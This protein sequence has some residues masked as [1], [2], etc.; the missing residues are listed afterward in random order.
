MEMDW[1]WSRNEIDGDGAAAPQTRMQGLSTRKNRRRKCDCVRVGTINITAGYGKAAANL[2]AV[3]REGHDKHLDLI[4]CTETRIG[5]DKHAQ[6]SG[7]YKIFATE[8]AQNRGGVAFFIRQRRVDEPALSW[9]VE[10]PQVFDTNVAAVTLVS[11]LWRRRIIGVYLSPTDI[12]DATWAGLHRACD[13]ATD[14]IWMMGDYNANLHDT[15]D[16]RVNEA[17]GASARST[18][19]AEIQAFISSLGIRSFGRTKLHRRKQ[20]FWT[21][22]L[23]R[24]VQ[25]AEQ[26]IKSV[27]D[28]ILGPRTD[29]IVKYRTRDVKWI[30]TDHR[31][32]YMD[33]LTR[34]QQHLTYIRG[35]K[36]FPARNDPISSIDQEYAAV[37]KLQKSDDDKER[38]P[39]R[40]T[41]ILEKTWDLMRRRQKMRRVSGPEARKKRAAMKRRLR[42]LLKRDRQ[43]S[44]DDE[45]K[46]IE[47]AMDNDS[48]AK[49]G[50]QMLQKWYKRRCGVNLQMSWRKL[51]E[52]GAEYRQLYTAT[53][54]PGEMF[55]LETVKAKHFEV[56][57]GP[58]TSD[59]IRA[60]AKRL[61]T[62]RAPGSNMFRQDTVRA[63]AM[64]ELGTKNADNFA[65]LVS[66]CQK[67]YE[68]G[69]I[70][71]AM[72]EGI[73][74]L[75]PKDGTKNNFRGITLLDTAYKLI[76][77]VINFRAS[78][79]IEFTK[80]VHGF[81]AE[82]GCNTAIQEAKWDMN[83][84]QQST[85][86]YHQVFLDLSKAFDTVDRPRLL[87]IMKA[88]G[89]GERSMRFFTN[90]WRDSYVAPRAGGVFGPRVE[91]HAG[92]RQ[93][94]VISPLLFNLVVDSILRNVDI[95]LPHLS[96]SVK[97]IFYADNGRIGGQDRGG[98]QTVLDLVTSNFATV[99]LKLNTTKTVSMSNRKFFRAIHKDVQARLMEGDGPTYEA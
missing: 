87:M 66:L 37:A 81:R 94:D 3:G 85:E 16:A 20:G 45:A 55:S 23:R 42:R 44:F 10:D 17:T 40:P 57:D 86:P 1:E 92:V 73:L 53:T 99:G 35:R 30:Q 49:A 50:F 60:A 84:R 63:W 12:S 8:T 33:C 97:K 9:S 75:I 14:P 76:A 41:W 98:V 32:V 24:E 56:A 71:R 59:E 43:Q 25:G 64:S 51:D 62:G 11:G 6:H 29:P 77:S 46:R 15:D 21:W 83:A 26:H 91:V 31:M 67:I 80:G 95:Q 18:R 22:H 61:R 78:K 28:Y 54:P 47:E 52:V 34:R 72:R 89:F 82:R 58:L 19:G 74:V 39:E 7:G 90:C 13:E 2:Q 93:G 70:P 88:Y 38:G 96:M 48:S 68:T 4:L 36:K 5:G 79:A 65:R 27:C 69:Q